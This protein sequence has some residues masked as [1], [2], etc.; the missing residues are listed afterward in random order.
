MAYWL[1]KSEPDAFSW[2]K[3]KSKGEKGQEWDGVRNYAARNNMRLMK[4]G[5][6]GFFYHSNEGREVVGIA[7]VCALAHPDSTADNPTWECVDIRAV[8]DIP[9][10]MNLDDI[11]ADPKL[12]EM[13]LVKNSR[14]SVQPVTDEEYFHICKQCGLDNPPKSP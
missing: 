12:A 14:L 6:K 9:K 1:F 5:D 13:I 3:L 7:E 10:P 11:K 4:I 2:E 8:V